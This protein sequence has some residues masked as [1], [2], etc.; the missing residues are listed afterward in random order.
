[1]AQQLG[2]ALP[3]V[4]FVH[5]FQRK[6]EHKYNPWSQDK[7]TSDEEVCDKSPIGY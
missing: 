3:H 2:K 6:E 4:E 7:G 5:N 1:M